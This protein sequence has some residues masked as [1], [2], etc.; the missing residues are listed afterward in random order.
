MHD[1][2]VNCGTGADVLADHTDLSGDAAA[3]Y[4]L[5]GKQI[6]QL[7]L[8]TGRILSWHHGNFNT[9]ALRCPTHRFDRLRLIIFNA[10]NGF[11][12]VNYVLKNFNASDN[13]CRTFTHQHV[14]SGDVGLALC[15]IDDEL[16]D[17]VL[18]LGAE[19]YCSRKA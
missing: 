1:G 8:A 10:D 11:F 2:T 15:G 3:W 9:A 12:T 6:D 5:A 14:V 13:V 18:W 17:F 7:L 16:F 19:L 4:F